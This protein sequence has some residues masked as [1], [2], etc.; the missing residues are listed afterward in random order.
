MALRIDPRVNK[1]R[2]DQHFC[3][4]CE[5]PAAGC[6]TTVGIG[7]GI[8]PGWGCVALPE[9]ARLVYSGGPSSN[10]LNDRWPL[11]LKSESLGGSSGGGEISTTRGAGDFPGRLGALF[12]TLGG[13]WGG[14]GETGGGG[15]GW[16][17][18]VGCAFGVC[19]SASKKRLRSSMKLRAD[20]GRGLL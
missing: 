1:S 10:E 18:F 9:P 17:T 7:A 20:A 2:I 8:L 13:D 15:T 14:G 16:R 19:S 4:L 6:P 5:V 12:N 3:S 11:S